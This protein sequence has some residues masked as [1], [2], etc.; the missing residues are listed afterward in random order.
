MLGTQRKKS[1]DPSQQADPVLPPPDQTRVVSAVSC[2]E[3]V[4]RISRWD[5][6]IRD[7]ELR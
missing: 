3:I 7:S 4:P 6:M 2:V 5:E 1:Q